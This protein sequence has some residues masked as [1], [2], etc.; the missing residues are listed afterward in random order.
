MADL[1]Q[2]RR[3]SAAGGRAEDEALAQLEMELQVQ[4]SLPPLKDETEIPDAKP[5]GKEDHGG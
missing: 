1:Q 5:E 2:R 3:R 4:D